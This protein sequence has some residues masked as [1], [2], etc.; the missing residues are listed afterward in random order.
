MF[1]AWRDLRFA[2]GRFGL[3]AGVVALMTLLIGFLSGLTAG[4]ADQNISAI[5]HID[6]DEIVLAAPKDAE[7]SYTNSS[8]SA[9]QEQA[10]RDV[11]GVDDVQPIGISQLRGT[12]GHQAA[13]TVMG[14]TAAVDSGSIVLSQGAADDLDAE[15][16][17]HV[18]IAGSEFTVSEIGDDEWFSHTPVVQT[19][20][21]DWR[22]IAQATGERDAHASA[23]LITG[24]PAGDV[25]G[26]TALSGLGTFTA[27]ES[28]RSETG[29]LLLMTTMLFAIGALVVGA[30]F[31]VWTI[32]RQGDIAVL[33]ALG[34]STGTLL[35]DA[36]GQ[37][38]IVLCIGVGAGMAATLGL[39]ALA[40]S[41]L[42]FVIS[43]WTTALPA[44]AL[45][46]LGLLGAAVSLRSVIAT[47]PLTALGSNR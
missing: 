36:M 26:T 44:V 2:K 19:S 37:A 23:L 43:I 10:W 32:Q 41:A 40:A 13:I 24:E 18:S 3:I 33:K 20:Q 25:A 16:G 4:L 42:P 17:D 31:T 12:G 46:V 15:P 7:P 45:I 5:D 14:G 34:A 21:A 11:D 1:V 38:L 6:A 22:D 39:G 47:D 28:F 30:F 29:S 35:R 8:I 9:E 27:I